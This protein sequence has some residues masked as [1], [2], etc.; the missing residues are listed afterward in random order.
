M[1]KRAWV[2][3]V[4]WGRGCGWR[5][6]GGEEGV[7]GGSGVQRL[8]HTA[9]LCPLVLLCLSLDVPLLSWLAY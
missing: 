7:G 8:I 4:G 3:G 2:E 5:D 9:H 6:W 1:G